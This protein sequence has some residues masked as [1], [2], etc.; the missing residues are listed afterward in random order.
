[1]KEFKPTSWSIDNS[2]SIFIITVLITLAGIMSYNALPKEQFPDVVVPTIFVSTIYPGASPSDMEQ[3]VTKPIEKQLKGISGVKKVSSYSVQDFSNVIVEFNTNLDVPLCKQKVKDAVDKAMRDLPTDLPADPTITEFDISEIPIM[4]VNVA[5]DFSLD[6]LKDYADALKDRIEEMR[7]ITRVD[8]VGALEKEIQVDV[9]KYKMAAASLTFRDIENAL[10]FENMTISAGNVDVD[11]MTRSVSIRGDFQNVE[12]IKNILVSSQSGAQ[13]YLKDIAEVRMGHK[14]QESFSRLNGRNVISL[15]VIKRTGENLIDASDKIKEVVD[16]MKANEFPANLEVTITGDQSRATRVTLHDLINTIII[17]FI[18]VTLV[19]MFFMGATDAIFVALSVPLSMCLAFMVLPSLGFTLNFIVLFAFLLALGIVVDDAIVVVE[20]THR[21]YHEDKSLTI[22]QAAKK[23]TGEVFLPVLSGTITT[24]APFFPLVFWGGIFG[25][26]MHYL[27][28]TVIITLTASLLV[29]YII[30]PVFAVWFMGDAKREGRELPPAKKRRRAMFGYVIFGLSLVYFYANGNFFMG[31]LLLFI[32][33]FVAFYRFVLA[34]VVK[35]FQDKGWPS[36]QN[37]YA[38]FLNF[39]LKNSALMMVSVVGL[40]IFSMVLFLSGKRNIVLFPKAE[41]NFIYVYLTLPV[42]TDVNVTD[43]LTRVMEGKVVEVLGQD[44]PIVESIISN[45]ALGASED[46]FDRAATSNK[47]KVGVAFVEFS[48]RNGVSTKAYMDKIREATRGVIPGAE[49]VV[50][51]EQGGPP[52]PKP[53]SVEVRGDDFNQLVKVSAAVK[54]YLDSLNIPGVEELRSDMVVSKPEINIQIDRDR[55]N[56]EGISTAQIGSEFRTAILG[57]E[58]TK[59]KD[60]E[61]EIPVNIRLREEQRTNINAVENL[62]ITFRDMNMGG[63]LRSV[64][65][66]SLAEVKYTT[67]YGG[68]RRLDQSRIVTIS[69]NI[70]SEYQPSQTEVVNAVKAAIANWPQTEGVTVGFAGEDAEMA[71]AF[72]F[73]GNALI[74]SLFIILII[75][76]TQFNSIGK[77]IIIMTEVIFSIIGV[78]LGMAITGMDFSVIMSMVGIVA[79]AG[80]VVRNGILL[81]EYTDIL[82]ERGTQVREA[83]VEAGR[84]R[85]TPVLLTA[86]AAILGLIPLAV[87]FNID[88]YSLF[89]TGDPKIYLGGD[90]VAFWGPLSWTII[91][92][93]SF[94]TFVTL[95]ILPVMYLLGWKLKNWWT[96]H[97]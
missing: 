33:A 39:A 7:E 49:I 64:P 12:Q 66:A 42:G 53:I 82:R 92:G 80:I 85:M 22:V 4:N 67:T 31:N 54:R 32:A 62:N 55:A 10:A 83:I 84:I 78:L 11:G 30:N 93:L 26:F 21:I 60:G 28:V 87:G 18:L 56:R 88:F 1:M 97:M 35:W 79:L 63:V 50:D 44:N 37:A 9:D 65:M 17:G 27:P 61:D 69:S 2:T 52:T 23:A 3:L 8:L 95:V 41:P 89:A 76:I 38:R 5:G 14:E 6:K 16:E 57:K 15:N 77:T 70:T 34:G 73:L 19:L 72:S 74:I 91:F 20:N 40:L 71:D 81:V 58:A 90:S 94:A 24:L 48:Q 29:A 45:V 25:K 86:T 43:S 59:F 13:L 47:G 75:L 68:I 51:Q 36:V 46:Q 96:T